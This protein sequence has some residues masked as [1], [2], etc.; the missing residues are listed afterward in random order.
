MR[1]MNLQITPAPR[2][3]PEWATIVQRLAYP[4]QAGETGPCKVCDEGRLPRGE[5]CRACGGDREA[6][7]V[8][9]ARLDVTE[10]RIEEACAFLDNLEYE[11]HRWQVTIPL[12]EYGG[13]MTN[14]GRAVVVCGITGE[15]LRSY[16]GRAKCNEAHAYFYPHAALEVRYSHSRG[17]GNGTVTLVGVDNQAR[18]RLGVDEVALWRFDDHGEIEVLDRHRASFITYPKAAVEAAKAKA[19]D[20]HCRSAYYAIGGAGGPSGALRGAG[21]AFGGQPSPF[22][23]PGR[24]Y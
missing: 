2:D 10:A 8:H 13:G 18:H 6:S 21:A 7:W 1:K 5:T 9:M 23:G 19:R 3:L 24:G 16:G 20:Y 14:T 22:K 11:A 4:D 12:V 15:R 17:D